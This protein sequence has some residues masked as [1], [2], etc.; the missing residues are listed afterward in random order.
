MKN[1]YLLLENGKIFKGTAFGADVPSTIGELV[2]STAVC[3]YIET[4]TDKRYFGQIV[5]QTFP[6]IGN[7][8]MIN[9]DITG[10]C[11]LNG[12]I[13]RDLCDAPSNFRTDTTLDA[14]LKKVGVPGI[15]G[16][17]TREIT[18]IIREQGVMNAIICDTLPKTPSF[19]YSITDAVKY[20]TSD[21]LYDFTHTNFKRSVVILNNGMSDEL[22]KHLNDRNVSIMVLPYSASVTDI[23]SY[24]PDGII[25]S[26]GP[27]NPCDNNGEISVVS[28]LIGKL[29]IF[30]VGLGHQIIA[31]A[32]GG[33]TAKHK[34]GHHGS[35]QPV[36]DVGGTRTYIT[37]QN[38]CYVVLPDSV[39]CGKMS[40]VNINDQSCEG[41]DYPDKKAFT[42]QFMPEVSDSPNDMSF[43]YD[44]FVAMLGGE[45]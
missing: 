4:L 27:G 3:G 33:K 20:V 11:F 5:L 30:G 7:Y 8:G 36:K 43:I 16:I 34:C 24:N 32:L 26:D 44:R 31:L 18:K 25:I 15:Y 9:E 29:P 45:C 42:L 12:Y 38:H 14:Y 21:K 37:S 13:V 39:P 2:F 41:M 35:N 28:E 6:H 40:Y 23:M 10:D 17:D 19:D 22:V 1:R